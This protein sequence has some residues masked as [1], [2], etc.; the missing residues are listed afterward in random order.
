MNF[1]CW[2]KLLKNVAF[3]IDLKYETKSHPVHI[4]SDCKVGAI[5][6]HGIEARSGSFWSA[7]ESELR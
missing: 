4:K 1:V 2:K 3:P 5:C 7:K 6:C